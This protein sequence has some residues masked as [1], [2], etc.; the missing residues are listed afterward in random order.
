MRDIIQFAVSH[1]QINE[2]LAILQK[3]IDQIN[4]EFYQKMEIKF[5]KSSSNE[6]HLSGLLRLNLSNKDIAIIKG[7]SVSSA[8]MGQYQL[9]KKLGLEVEEDIRAFLQ[10][11]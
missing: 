7:I 9:R 2:D 6:K 8:N 3:N 10:G 1:L 5:G 4:Q 11:I